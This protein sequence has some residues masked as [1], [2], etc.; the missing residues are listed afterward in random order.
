MGNPTP[1]FEER[2]L[3]KSISNGR[4]YV[5]MAAQFVAALLAFQGAHLFWSMNLT[6]YHEKRHL[7]TLCTSDLNVWHSFQSI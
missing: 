6:S 1:I 7:V 2:F 3:D 4:F 5:L